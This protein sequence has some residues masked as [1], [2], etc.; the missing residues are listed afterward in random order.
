M[1]LYSV[2]TEDLKKELQRRESDPG[3][4][5]VIKYL[6]DDRSRRYNEPK[7]IHLIEDSN[8]VQVEVQLVGNIY[9]K[10]LNDKQ[11]TCSDDA[12]NW[13]SDWDYYDEY[14]IQYFI[15]KKVRIDSFDPLKISEII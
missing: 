6:R 1:K 11:P 8:G 4:W 12:P 15:G 14:S 10:D 13:D 5:S 7:Y 2:S 9:N 3:I